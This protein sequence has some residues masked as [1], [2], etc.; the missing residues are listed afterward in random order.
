[1]TSR[2]APRA[3]AR[4]APD[5]RAGAADRPIASAAT[6]RASGSPENS[7]SIGVASAIGAAGGSPPRQRASATAAQPGGRSTWQRVHASGR[8][9]DPPLPWP[10]ARAGRRDQ[11]GAQLPPGIS[12]VHAV[13]ARAGEG[14]ALGTRRLEQ[15]L[16]L[17]GREAGRPVGPEPRRE[18][19][20]IAA[21]RRVPP[22]RLALRR[23]V[24]AGDKRISR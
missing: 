9:G 12:L 24:V 8:S 16:V 11:R 20:A 4:A 18:R 19:L 21:Q 22:E 13:A 1:M 17:V 23:Q 10:A 3:R 14:P 6:T 5:A 7:V 15:A 2:S